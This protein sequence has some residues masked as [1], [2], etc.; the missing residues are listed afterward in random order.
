MAHA[1]DKSLL[2]SRIPPLKVQAETIKLSVAAS[3]IHVP[4]DR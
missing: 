4:V 2:A 1:Q 3:C